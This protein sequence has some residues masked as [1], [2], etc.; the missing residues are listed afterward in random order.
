MPKKEWSTEIN[1]HRVS[2]IN[3]WFRGATLTIDGRVR[4]HNNKMFA[5]SGIDRLTARLNENDP[6]SPQVD[7]FIRA[8]FR[9][10]CKICVDGLP[11]GG[12]TF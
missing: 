9:V 5:V 1:G 10:K 8:I 2:V 7:A 12:D 11:V 6:Q 4:D 3:T